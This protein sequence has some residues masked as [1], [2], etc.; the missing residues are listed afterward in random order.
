MKLLV[1]RPI[2][3]PAV[4]RLRAEPGVETTVLEEDVSDWTARC[5]SKRPRART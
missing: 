1:T 4:A 3:E 5:C 2:P